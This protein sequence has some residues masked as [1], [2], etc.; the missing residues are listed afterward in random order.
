MKIE[1]KHQDTSI[2]I[3]FTPEEF[4]KLIPFYYIR[5]LFNKKTAV[6]KNYSLLKSVLTECQTKYGWK[7]FALEKVYLKDERVILFVEQMPFFIKNG[8]KNKFISD[9]EIHSYEQS[10]MFFAVMDLLFK[11]LKKGDIKKIF[12]RFI[13]ND[14]ASPIGFFEEIEKKKP[15]LLTPEIKDF[16]ENEKLKWIAENNFG[17]QQ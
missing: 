11:K 17:K 4:G 3:E 15:K 2:A 1:T 16:L 6:I 10:N 8:V 12:G 5:T 14:Q 9:Y 7:K 13:G